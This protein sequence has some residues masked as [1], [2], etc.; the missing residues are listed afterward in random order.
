M[1]IYRSEISQSKAD[2]VR[3][4]NGGIGLSLENSMSQDE[5]RC[6]GAVR[7]F[8]STEVT[9]AVGGDYSEV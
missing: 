1:L 5:S 6:L 7:G 2:S 4:E 8:S 3:G 9:V